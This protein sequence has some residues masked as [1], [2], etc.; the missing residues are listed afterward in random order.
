MKTAKTLAWTGMISMVISIP[1]WYIL[2]PLEG[3]LVIAA[4]ALQVLTASIILLNE[5]RKKQEE[6]T[7][8]LTH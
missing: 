6:E 2:G 8:K 5:E 3:D 1:V 7:H 4:G